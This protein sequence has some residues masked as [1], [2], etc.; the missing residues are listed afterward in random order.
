[1]EWTEAGVCGLRAN[2]RRRLRERSYNF[3]IPNIKPLVN[4]RQCQKGLTR[5]GENKKETK[6]CF[7]VKIN[8]GV[9]L[10]IKVLEC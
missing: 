1:M 3:G 2:T 8:V 4:L 9:Y 6:S 10:E 5:A 7:Q